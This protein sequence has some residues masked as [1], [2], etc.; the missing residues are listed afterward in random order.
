MDILH[1]CRI[2]QTRGRQGSPVE[3]LLLLL[4]NIPLICAVNR[5]RDW[6]S[7]V[8]VDES[9]K[10]TAEELRGALMNGAWTRSWTRIYAATRVWRLILYPAF[11]MDTVKMLMAI[12][13]RISFWNHIGGYMLS[14]FR[15]RIA[16]GASS[17][18]RYLYCHWCSTY[19]INVQ[20][21]TFRSLQGSGNT[22]RTGRSSLT[23]S[24]RTSR[25]LLIV[26]SWKTLCFVL[27]EYTVSL[28]L[29]RKTQCRGL[30]ADIT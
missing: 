30:H 4:R 11:D 1:S 16:P 17:L 8:D 5:L 23:I 19:N 28:L 24:T 18:K 6:F 12:Y 3:S 25:A 14:F 20:T 13:V 29:W 22:S 10:I 15:I 2:G 27:G 7:S 26:T 9:G 21:I